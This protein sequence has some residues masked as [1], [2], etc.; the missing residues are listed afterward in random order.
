MGDLSGTVSLCIGGETLLLHPE[1]AVLWP[2]AGAVIVADIHFGKSSSFGRHGLAVPA[3]SDQEDRA[4][5]TRLIE[6][7][8]SHRLIILGDFFHE[9]LQPK[10]AESIDLESWSAAL[11]RTGVRIQV[12]AGNHDRGV[13]SGWRGSMEWI[14]G[15]LREP[16]FRFVHDSARRNAVRQGA[17]T[18]SGHIHPVMALRGLRKRVARVPVFWQ[19]EQGMELPS[20]GSFTGGYLISPAPGDRI[21]AVSPEGVVPFPATSNRR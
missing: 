2:R 7:F 17:F 6:S 11:A 8:D 21:Y 10:S 20:F 15:E 13:Q 12:I 5:L 3:G 16:P 19:R 14:E 1:R 4:R 9:P 18:L